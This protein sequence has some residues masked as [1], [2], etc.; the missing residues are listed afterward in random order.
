MIFYNKFK[1][2]WNPFKEL[3]VNVNGLSFTAAKRGKVICNEAFP[4]FAGEVYPKSRLI[5]I[6]MPIDIVR[7]CMDNGELEIKEIF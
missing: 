2:L 4:W 6:E 3:T 5:N 7:Y 1:N